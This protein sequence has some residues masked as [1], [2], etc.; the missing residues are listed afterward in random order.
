[1]PE[2][3]NIEYK[4]IWKDEYL[5]WICGFANAQ[6]GI[7]FIGKDDDGSVIGLQNSKKLLEDIP[8]KIKDI[9]GI[10]ADVNLYETENGEYIEIVVETQINPV[11]YK[12]EYHY[13]SGSTKQELK[14][15]ALDKFLLQKYG[16]KWDGVPIPNVSVADLKQEAFAFFK[17]KGIE[18]KRLDESSRKDT[19]EQLLTNLNLLDNG[20]LKRAALLLFHPNPEKFVTGA[21]IKIGFF[22][23]DSDLLF[24]DDIHGNLFE[25]VE[26]TMELLLTK[27]TKALISYKGLSRIETYEYPEKALREAL[28]N[29]VAH[30]DYAGCTPIQIS[31]YNDKVMFWNMGQL[32]ENWTVEMLQKKHSSIPY[33][34]DIANAFF[35][36]GYIEAWGRGIEKINENCVEAGLPLPLIYYNTGGCWVEF[37]KDIYNTEN[38]R[39]K[40]LNERQIKA[41]L[42]VKE[43]G[44]ITN[45]EYQEINEISDRTSSRDLEDLVAKGVL[46]KI[47]DKK[48]SYYEI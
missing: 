18:S 46:R 39:D 48:S 26:K 17:E 15:A 19:P 16:K 29:A 28:L 20:Y 33:N 44:R 40:G 9:L 1:M 12:G 42:Y 30:K 45:S 2:K 36:S 25:Q 35:R 34:P 24:Q 43:K 13:R 5:K 21:Y 8:N 31:V 10:I 27:Y 11:N 6:G 47:G 37:R 38:L 41:V 3:Q 32:P 4:K 23:T 7:I 14:G 22:R